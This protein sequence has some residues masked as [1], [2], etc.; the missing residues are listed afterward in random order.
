MSSNSQTFHAKR[1]E[2]L[3]EHQIG[4]LFFL[5]SCHTEPHH[6]Q[7]LYNSVGI[8]F[9]GDIFIEIRLYIPTE[10]MKKISHR[11]QSFTQRGNVYALVSYVV[12]NLKS[13]LILCHKLTLPI[14]ANL[15]FKNLRVDKACLED[16]S[17]SLCSSLLLP[18]Y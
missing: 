12:L 8:E 10:C 17:L 3:S 15:L 18:Q 11:D 9:L 1:R 7:S 6:G 5:R 16:H 2:I 13:F 14:C 4:Q